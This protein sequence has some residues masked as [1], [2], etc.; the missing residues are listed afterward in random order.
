MFGMIRYFCDEALL[1]RSQSAAA[2]TAITWKPPYRPG[3]AF[4]LLLRTGSLH[5]LLSKPISNLNLPG[6]LRTTFTTLMKQQTP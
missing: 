4:K 5:L 6:G 1:L 3:A 2:Q